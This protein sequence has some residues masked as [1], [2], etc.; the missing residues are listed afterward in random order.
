MNT[1]GSRAG[2]PLTVQPR[3]TSHLHQFPWPSLPNDNIGVVS[4]QAWLSLGGIDM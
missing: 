4:P 3:L 1:V 2:L